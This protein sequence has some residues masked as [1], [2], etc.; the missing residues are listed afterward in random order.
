[1]QDGGAS[2]TA[3]WLAPLVAVGLHVVAFCVTLLARDA[4]GIASASTV[5][6]LAGAAIGVAS[7]LPYELK[8]AW[9][10][11]AEGCA[12]SSC[13]LASR[14]LW[15]PPWVVLTAVAVAFSGILCGLL[16]AVRVRTALRG[17]RWVRAALV[18]AAVVSVG[19]TI[20][21]GALIPGRGPY[22]ASFGWNGW[23]PVP[24]RVLSDV[25]LAPGGARL[26]RDPLYDKCGHLGRADQCVY[27]L[28]ADK[29]VVVD[30]DVEAC[31]VVDCHNTYKCGEIEARAL[32]GTDT[33]AVSRHS[34]WPRLVVGTTLE[35]QV[36]SEAKVRGGPRAWLAIATLGLLGVGASLALRS[37][38]NRS[39]AAKPA[40]AESPY[41][42]TRTEG[43]SDGMRLDV[44]TTWYL[45]LVFIVTCAPSVL[46]FVAWAIHAGP[47]VR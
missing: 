32:P 22:L 31:W 9:V 20:V 43:G 12:V 16:G 39:K 10:R 15:G 4:D 23:Q 19:A 36:P 7:L 3:F 13:F 40:Q 29:C 35:G 38:R 21:D 45:A 41:R 42:K 2:R 47:T 37:L 14:A 34:Q 17:A 27:V 26:V 28:A 18:I 5:A 1:V 6:A 25:R 24:T 33:M 30:A 8:L 46:A 11:T 44:L